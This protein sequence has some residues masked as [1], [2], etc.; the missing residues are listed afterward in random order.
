MSTRRTRIK[1]VAS[2]P[3]RR[4]NNDNLDKSKPTFI[5][6]DEVEKLKSPKTPRSSIKS[7]ENFGKDSPLIKAGS[8]LRSPKSVNIIKDVPKDVSASSKT[9]EKVSVISTI[10]PVFVSPRSVDSPIRKSTVATPKTSEIEVD[11]QKIVTPEKNV[12]SPKPNYNT[13]LNTS[14]EEI[15]KTP[16]INVSTATNNMKNDIPDGKCKTPKRWSH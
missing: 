12:E 3:P 5:S 10:K 13:G 6:K 9:S 7:Q 2:L 1:A 15:R 16:T 14:V 4:K 11:A 8:P